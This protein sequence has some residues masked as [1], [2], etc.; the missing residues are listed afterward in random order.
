MASSRSHRELIYTWIRAPGQVIPRDTL[1]K[2]CVLKPRESIRWYSHDQQNQNQS[3]TE[4]SVDSGYRSGL[5]PT[6]SKSRAVQGGAYRVERILP[7][8][9]RIYLAI[10]IELP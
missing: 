6:N 9:S 10:R 4:S 1:Q 3:Q 7:L 8:S 2:V 5:A